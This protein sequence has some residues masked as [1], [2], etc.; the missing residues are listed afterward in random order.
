MMTTQY[1]HENGQQVKTV[2][3]K[4]SPLKPDETTIDRCD[5]R[6]DIGGST[7]NRLCDR[8]FDPMDSES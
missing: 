1:E 4:M 5:T 7:I 8:D 6:K 3:W 2:R